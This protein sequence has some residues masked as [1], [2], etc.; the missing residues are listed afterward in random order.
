MSPFPPMKPGDQLH[1]A[2]MTPEIRERVKKASSEL[3]DWLVKNTQT[4]LEAM[5]VL[6]LVRDGLMQQFGMRVSTYLGA[7]DLKAG[8]A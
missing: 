8:R 2:E 4:P 5:M 1:L 3:I 6:D 7:D